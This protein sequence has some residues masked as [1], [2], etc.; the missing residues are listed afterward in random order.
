MGAQNLENLLAILGVRLIA[1][2]PE[3]GGWRIADH[4]EVVGRFEGEVDEVLVD[5]AADPVVGAID[6]VH[7]GDLPR[8]DDSA[9]QR[10]IN[11]R[12]GARRPERS[13]PC[14]ST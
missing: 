5:D 9:D 10:L 8:F 13:V 7:C 4:F 1:R 3:R 12:R 6:A 2:R 11:D 14:L